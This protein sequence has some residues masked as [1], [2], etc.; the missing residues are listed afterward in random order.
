MSSVYI[1]E[2]TKH[3]GEEVT[4][5]GWLYNKTEKGKLR[6]LLVR[7]GTGII[8]AVVF[9]KNVPPAVFQAVD[10]LTQE[11][12]LTLTGKVR[13]DARAPGGCE[14]DVTDLKVLQVAEEYPITPKEHGT[15]FLMDHRHLWLRSA[16]QHAVLLVRGEI[17]KACRDFFGPR[18]VHPGGRAHFYPRGL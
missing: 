9:Q 14:L 10:E 1:E 13:E 11:S 4:L 8:Q 6:F 18:G 16:R 7:D 15:A 5:K 17:I 12:S 2:I 3:F